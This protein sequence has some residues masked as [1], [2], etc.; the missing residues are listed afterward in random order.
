MTAARWWVVAVLAG[1]V[2]AIPARIALRAADP[3][4]QAQAPPAAKPAAAAG[5][6]D[7]VEVPPP[8]FSD[9]IFPARSATSI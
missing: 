1:P 8:P 4:E 2:V 9:G 6:Q 3:P 7:R 5:T